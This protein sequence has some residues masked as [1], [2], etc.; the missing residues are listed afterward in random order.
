MARFCPRPG[1]PYFSMRHSRAK[2]FTVLELM[3]AAGVFALLAAIAIAGFRGAEY[4]RELVSA[5]ETVAAAIRD[6]EARGLG[7]RPG[8]GGLY[9]AG[10]WGIQF[11]ADDTQ[12]VIFADNNEDGFLQDGGDAPETVE[13]I[14]LAGRDRVSIGALD[15]T[16]PEGASI[17]TPPGVSQ[18]IINGNSELATLT[19]TLV[20]VISG[21]KKIITVNRISGVVDVD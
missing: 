18:I 9:P 17:T 1:L 14:V 3:V 16:T 7:V 19:I 4:N 5:A 15:P 2:G 8:P 11:V 10:G 12:T 6:V 13:T 21:A 20:H